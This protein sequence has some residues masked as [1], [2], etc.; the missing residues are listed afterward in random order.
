MHFFHTT[1]VSKYGY[2]KPDAVDEVAYDDT[3]TPL[4][5]DA[6][7]TPTHEKPNTFDDS[8]LV[9]ETF[10]QQDLTFNLQST[11][12]IGHEQEDTDD[13]EPIYTTVVRYKTWKRKMA[14]PPLPSPET[15]T[16]ES[17]IKPS[18]SSTCSSTNTK[19]TSFLSFHRQQRMGD[20]IIKY[21]LCKPSLSQPQ[22]HDI[23]QSD[24]KQLAFKKRQTHS[25]SWGFCNLLYRVMDNDQGIQVAEARRK[26]FQK[27]ITVE[28]GDDD[29]DNERDH[30][31]LVNTNH[32]RLLFVFK[33]RFGN[34]YTIRWKRPSLASHDLVCDIR[35]WGQWQRLAEFDSH[36]MGYLVHVGQLTVDKQILSW[37][38]YPDH[39]E[40]HLLITCSTL[41]DLMRELVQKAIGLSHGGV[42]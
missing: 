23:Y 32:T 1:D 2:L 21:D 25:Y 8:T 22:H 41:V 13:D 31:L 7:D 28:W 6:I 24:T 18:N 27:H 37:V 11:H 17:N 34:D 19:H 26:A 33:T 15:T 36:L 42:A 5:P 12:L 29:D 40:A 35:R 14:P 10:E 20:D 9:D 39:L 30:E 3:H 16:D 4:K 38:D